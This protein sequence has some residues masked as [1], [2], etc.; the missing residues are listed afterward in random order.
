VLQL[1]FLAAKGL[2]ESFYS[3]WVMDHFWLLLNTVK[4]KVLVSPT[5]DA[6]YGRN[7]PSFYFFL[8]LPTSGN[9]LANPL[10]AQKGKNALGY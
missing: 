5:L 9:R 10:S 8:V 3:F 2:F 4:N 1:F 6:D 7:S